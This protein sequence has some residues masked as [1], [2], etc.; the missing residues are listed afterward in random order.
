MT[1]FII[2]VS[3]SIIAAIVLMIL[4]EFPKTLIYYFKNKSTHKGLKHIFKL[5]HYID[6]VGLLFFVTLKVGFS[7]PYMCSNKDKK[8]NIILGI[9]GFLVLIIV[10]ISSSVGLMALYLRGY[11]DGSM[12]LYFDEFIVYFLLDLIIFSGNMFIVNLFPISTFDIAQIIAGIK[13]KVYYSLVQHDTVVK[14]I[15][16]IAI[17]FGLIELVGQLILSILGIY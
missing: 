12:N 11:L 17:I 1:E 14:G 4:H 15:L 5:H 6:P 3:A 9:T 2:S 16:I 13:P 7:K 8:T 10:C